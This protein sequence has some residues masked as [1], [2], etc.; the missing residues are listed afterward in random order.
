MKWE[1]CLAVC[2]I[3]VDATSRELHILFSGCP[4]YFSWMYWMCCSVRSFIFC[5][6]ARP[7]FPFSSAIRYPPTRRKS[8]FSYWCT[9]RSSGGRFRCFRW[10]CE[11]LGLSGPLVDSSCCDDLSFMQDCAS[12]SF[13]VSWLF[14]FC[15]FWHRGLGFAISATGL[16]GYMFCTGVLDGEPWAHSSLKTM[17]QLVMTLMPSLISKK[18]SLVKVVVGLCYACLNTRVYLQGQT[19]CIGNLAGARN[20]VSR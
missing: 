19:V 15:V 11:L 16:S 7:S 20:V 8:W 14:L 13:H 1:A 17:W 12:V 10:C 2:G 18:T 9:D 4:G 3:P 6:S 5:A